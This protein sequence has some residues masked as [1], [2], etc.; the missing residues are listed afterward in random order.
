LAYIWLLEIGYLRRNYFSRNMNAITV[1]E[2]WKEG[3][4][5]RGNGKGHKGRI[6]WVIAE[7]KEG[8]Q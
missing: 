7:E 2:Y 8:G 1:S 5:G 6:C 4:P 3:I